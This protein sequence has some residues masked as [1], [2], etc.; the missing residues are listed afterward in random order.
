MSES[1]IVHPSDRD[2]MDQSSDESS[3][4][5]QPREPH[6]AAH[7]HR[8]REGIGGSNNEN[9]KEFRP[10]TGRKLVGID[11]QLILD[12]IAAGAMQREI[13]AELGVERPAISWYIAKTVDP[14][15]WATVKRES[16]HSRLEK[17]V[18]DMD[19]ARD[20]LT[21]ARARESARLWMWRA[22]REHPD[23]W[24]ARPT[25]AVQVNAG[26]SGVQLVVY[27]QNTVS[28][29]QQPADISAASPEL[30]KE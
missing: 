13:A 8:M 11:P 10:A 25:T 18:D 22:E 24:G 1:S 14:A 5:G 21:L 4:S 20:P 9:D 12:R 17:A 26:E 16:M 29:A 3:R 2:N 28:S 27:G 30:P 19:G 23:I 15:K 6:Q 7:Q